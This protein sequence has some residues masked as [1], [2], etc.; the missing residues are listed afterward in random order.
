VLARSRPIG[1]HALMEAAPSVT[2]VGSGDAFGPGGRLQTRVDVTF[3]ELAP[4]RVAKIGDG[5]VGEVA[6]VDHFCRSLPFAVRLTTPSGC[7]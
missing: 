1:H 4:G 7:M 2:L 6:E 3:V 5:R